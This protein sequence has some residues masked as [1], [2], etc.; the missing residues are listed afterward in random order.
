MKPKSLF[1]VLAKVGVPALALL[2]LPSCSWDCPGL[3]EDLPWFVAEDY[4]YQ[5][6]AFTDGQDTLRVQYDGVVFENKADKT[7]GQIIM[8][9]VNSW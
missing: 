5:T 7:L 8:E 4:M 6:V 3:P 9:C 1:H 2:F